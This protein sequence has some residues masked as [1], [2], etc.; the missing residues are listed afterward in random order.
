MWIQRTPVIFLM[1]AIVCFS[2][3]LV[4][5]S[6]SSKQHPG[7]SVT[8]V[9]LTSLSG[10]GLTAVLCWIA[11]E[12]WS[13]TQ[14]IYHII[15]TEMKALSSFWSALCR[16]IVWISRH[17]VYRLRRH[18]QDHDMDEPGRVD[19]QD[20]EVRGSIPLSPHVE[21]LA[22]F[23]T[24]LDPEKREPWTPGPLARADWARL[25]S[26]IARF[27]WVIE[28]VMAQNARRG[29]SRRRPSYVFGARLGVALD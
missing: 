16:S 19:S 26:P 12:R 20:L 9:A 11:L 5:F 29:S 8:T 10:L 7:T 23:R 4:L 13:Y 18:S 17:I 21:C 6:Y 25:T 22:A 24:S 1:L 2:V 3:G 15:S 27:K 14:I 28:M